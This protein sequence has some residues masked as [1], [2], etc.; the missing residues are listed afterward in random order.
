MAH[1]RVTEVLAE[2]RHGAQDARNELFRLVY[3]ELRRIAGAQ[4]RREVPGHT[5]TP[6]ALVHEAY[7]RL[8]GTSADWKDRSHFFTTAARA[9]RSIL[10]DCARSRMAQK[11]GGG[12]FRVTFDESTD[13]GTRPLEDIVA[14]HEA[15]AKL[16]ALDPEGSRIVELRFFA[17]LS[18]DETARVIETTKSA[19]YRSWNH[20]RAWLYCEIAP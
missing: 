13:A 16:E 11:R 3:G 19:V 14:V 18:L 10:V 2:L 12:R 6:T 15:L 20:A 8:M 1:E 5:L 4:M 9:M 17:G 7:L